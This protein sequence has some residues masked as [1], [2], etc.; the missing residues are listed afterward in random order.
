MLD[1]SHNAWLVATSLAVIMMAAFTGLYLTHG[2]SKLGN[3]RRKLTVALSAVVLGGGIWSMHFVAM[4]GL[5]LPILFYYDALITLIS[6]LVAILMVGLALLLLHFR[7]RTMPVMVGA[8]VIVGLGIVSMHY[9]GM[10]GMQLCRPVHSAFD[11]ILSTVA[12]VLLS[13][14]AIWIA[15]DSRTHR[16]ILL[17]TVCFAVAV[18]AMHFIA[19]GLTDF[20]VGDSTGGAGPALNNQVLAMGVTVSVF[21][22]CGGFLLTGITVI[23]PEPKIVPEHAPEPESEPAAVL[24]AGIPFEREGQTFFAEPAMIAAV[25]AEGHYTVLYMD[26]EKLFCPWSITEA[27]TRLT[28]DGFLRAHRSYLV[29]PKFVSSFERHKDNGTCYFDG[30]DA[31]TKVPVSRSRLNDIRDALGL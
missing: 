11:V 28:S 17:G 26:A 23:G 27:E 2:A 24:R 30:V 7:P 5:Q 25:R 12:S 19:T 13:V 16:N 6:A 3:Q 15:Y 22:I 10:A 9:I 14:L 4:L 8:G 18:F 1:Y 20:V 21:L 29:N 31:L